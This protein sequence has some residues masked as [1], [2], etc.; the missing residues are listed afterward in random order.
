MQIV[1]RT[2]GKEGRKAGG[3]TSE[4][5]GKSGLNEAKVGFLL[6]FFSFETLP[7]FVVSPRSFRQ[8]T[9]V[10]RIWTVELET[11]GTKGAIRRKIDV[12][13][14]V[15]EEGGIRSREAER[16]EGEGRGAAGELVG[17]WESG[18]SWPREGGV[19][20]KGKRKKVK[21]RRRRR[22]NDSKTRALLLHHQ[23][24]TTKSK[25]RLPTRDPA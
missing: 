10:D 7:V 15:K 21:R 20:R 23:S 2:D 9:Y 5:W 24:S 16:G 8:P 1:S 13:K 17:G 12:A 11:K 19:G 22:V 14:S 4:S 3:R 6:F 25:R 18:G